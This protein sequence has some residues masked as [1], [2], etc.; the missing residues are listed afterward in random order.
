MKKERYVGLGEERILELLEEQHA[1]IPTE[2]EARLAEIHKYDQD[3]EVIHP[4]LL[5]EA[6]H[7]LEREGTILRTSAISVG[8]RRVDVIEPAEQRKRKTAI[9]KAASWKRK[10]YGRYLALASK[11]ERY[12]EGRIGPAGERVLREGLLASQR[13]NPVHDDGSEV[14]HILDTRLNGPLDNAGFYVPIDTNRVPGTPITLLF[15][16]KNVRRWIYPTSSELY[17]LLSKAATVQKN[18]PSHLVLPVL[19]CRRAHYWTFSMAKDL[20]FFV[21]ELKKQYV[22]REEDTTLQE[23]RSALAFLDLTLVPEGGRSDKIDRSLTKTLPREAPNLAPRWQ[24]AAPLLH[25][26]IHAL[27]KARDSRQDALTRLAEAA[28]KH[29]LRQGEWGHNL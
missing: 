8:N 2:I 4:H 9:A 10:M 11:S 19:I 25:D 16:V 6:L 22:E 21:L 14:R 18:A 12:K 17:Q 20:G 7:N 23:I 13:I 26:E 24:I 29:G 28:E 27:H 15:E 5:S 1:L 3:P